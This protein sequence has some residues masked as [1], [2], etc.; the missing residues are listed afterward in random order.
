MSLTGRLMVPYV[1]AV[2][3][4]RG[5][6]FV[7]WTGVWHHPQAILF[8]RLTRGVVESLYRRSDAIIVYGDH[9]RRALLHV[10]GV[11]NDKIFTAAQAVDG[12]KFAT[13]ADV[14]KSKQLLFVGHFEAH[15]GIDDLLS[16]FTRVTDPSAQLSIVGNGP[17]ETGVQRQAA[18]DPRIKVVGFVPQQDLRTSTPAPAGW[19]CRPSRHRDIASAGVSSSTKRCTPACR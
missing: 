1:Y 6:P 8:H 16:A 11:D 7:L 3:R 18:V 10:R 12:R 14:A 13:D 2:A 4:A 15:K 5:V 19:C 17:L 9:V